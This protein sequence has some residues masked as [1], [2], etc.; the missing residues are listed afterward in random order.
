[1]S[2]EILRQVY[3]TLLYRQLTKPW[4]VAARLLEAATGD[5]PRDKIEIAAIATEV[6]GLPPEAVLKMTV[7]ELVARLQQ[8]ALAEPLKANSDTPPPSTGA[9]P[10]GGH[11][12]ERGTPRADARTDRPR[13]EPNKPS[14]DRQEDILAAIRDAKMPLTR[15]ELIDAMRLKN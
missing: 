2:D 11:Q 3:A 6:L 8:A 15:S 12:S 14:R 4:Q 10:A 1:M 9:M 7:H 13:R 5:R